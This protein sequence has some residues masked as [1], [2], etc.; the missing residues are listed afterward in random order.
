MSN[1]NASFNDIIMDE[2]ESYLDRQK[3]FL[4]DYALIIIKN[5]YYLLVILK[6][7]KKTP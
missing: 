7:R 5:I 2:K 1:R 3:D 4:I 6:F